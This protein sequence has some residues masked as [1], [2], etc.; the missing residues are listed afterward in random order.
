MNKAIH[1]R[2]TILGVM[3]FCQLAF[4]VTF[5]SIPPILGILVT[6]FNISYAQAGGLMSLF[7]FPRI[8]FALPSGLLVDRYGSKANCILSIL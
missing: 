8:F 4:A 5:Q 2:W 1:Y 6:T 3:T 7:S